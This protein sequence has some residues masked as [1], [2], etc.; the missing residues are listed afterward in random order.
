M[1]SAKTAAR[2]LRRAIQ[3]SLVKH[4]RVYLR[5]LRCLRRGSLEKKLYLALLQPGEVA[6]D[7]GANHGYFT[8]LFSDIVGA[9][10]QVHAFEPVPPTFDLLATFVREQ[11]YYENVMLTRAACSDR[12][13]NMPIFVPA[14]DSGQAS[15]KRHV[16]GSWRDGAGV[17]EFQ[18]T[19]IELDQYVQARNITRVDFLKCDVEG[20]ELLVLRGMAATLRTHHPLLLVEVYRGW[21]DTFGYNANTLMQFLNSVGY[22]RFQWV[23]DHLGPVATRES[24]G[25]PSGSVNLLCSASRVHAS[26]LRRLEML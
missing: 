3:V 9:S 21:T 6:F 7:V 1:R 14:G 16:E 20:A 5:A 25:I 2:T 12:Q 17:Q 26:R 11:Q 19:T 22:D 13:E 15:L 10:G 23:T 4:P 24:I 18:T 8:L